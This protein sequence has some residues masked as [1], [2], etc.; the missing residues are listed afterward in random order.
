M[1]E[2]LCIHHND[3]DGKCAAA[4]VGY[5]FR[6]KRVEDA[7]VV[8][9]STDYP[10][11]PP[12][13]NL[14]AGKEVVIVDFSFKLDVMNDIILL[15]KDVTWIDHHP[16]ARFYPYQSLPGFRDFRDKSKSGCELTWQYFFSDAM[17]YAVQLIGDYDKWALKINDSTNFYEG[18]KMQYNEPGDAIWRT[19]FA[20]H[21]ISGCDQFITEGKIAINYR[22]FYTK[23]LCNQYGYE[24]SIDGIDAY[25]CNF[26]NMGSNGFGPLFDKYPI[27]IS[28]IHNGGGFK[29]SLYSKDVDVSLI[30]AAYG[31][32]GH[33]G[34]AG[35]FCETLPFTKKG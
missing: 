24:T 2:I 9:F 27:C 13:S 6:Q 3:L 28:Y 18:M 17:P 33:K 35:F 34:A 10:L 22:K 11:P 12:A 16:S 30:A 26:Q 20:D 15:A 19:L 21:G 31:G 8:F 32:G 5:Y 14:Y 4:I 7:S 29:V 25:A 1:R 23:E